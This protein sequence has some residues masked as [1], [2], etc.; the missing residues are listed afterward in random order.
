[1]AMFKPLNV[2]KYHDNNEAHLALGRGTEHG[3][4]Q[5]AQESYFGPWWLEFLPIGAFLD[6]QFLSLNNKKI[7]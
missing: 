4:Y 5:A 3:I 7:A 6:S 2:G 1:M